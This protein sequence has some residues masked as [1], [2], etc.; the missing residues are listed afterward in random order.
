MNSAINI[1]KPHIKMISKY[2]T[3]QFLDVTQEQVK[4]A[5][6]AKKCR[7][8]LPLWFYAYFLLKLV[9]VIRNM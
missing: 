9:R 3:E 7:L 6:A 5:G 2:V 4:V 8:D 1:F